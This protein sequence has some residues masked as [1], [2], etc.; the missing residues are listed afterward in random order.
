MSTIR[1]LERKKESIKLLLFL[2]FR[3]V[4]V[5][6][7]AFS[8][9]WS[10]YTIAASADGYFEDHWA[11]EWSVNAVWEVLYVLILVAIAVLWMP[12]QNATRY[13]YS[14]QLRTFEGDEE[15]D[16]EDND[17]IGHLR[18]AIRGDGT[19]DGEYGG[20]LEDGEGA[21]PSFSEAITG[22]KEATGGEKLT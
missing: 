16:E 4:L 13:A 7:V 9:A 8:S 19:I 15:E 10:I 11:S 20:S 1:Y 12:S 6:S 3:A 21:L 5:V 18:C 2:R 14:M 17:D 22:T